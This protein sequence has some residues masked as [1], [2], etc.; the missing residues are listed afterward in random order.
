MSLSDAITKVFDFLTEYDTNYR[1]ETETL[2][3]SKSLLLEAEEFLDSHVGLFL[4]RDVRESS[5]NQ[6]F[7]LD[8]SRSVNRGYTARVI[9]V[10]TIFTEKESRQEFSE[11]A[12][13]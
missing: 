9:G 5:R 12:S 1:P 10:P 3:V 2:A 8:P 4:D 13:K 6:R 11:T 7:I